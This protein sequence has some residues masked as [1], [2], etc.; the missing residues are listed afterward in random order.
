MGVGA[1]AVDGSVIVPH[2]PARPVEHC[3]S[4]PAFRRRWGRV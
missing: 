4:A 2:D 1:A 3:F